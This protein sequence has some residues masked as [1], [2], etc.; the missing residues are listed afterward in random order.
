MIKKLLPFLL[1]GFAFGQNDL[2]K[3]LELIKELMPD[4]TRC[5]VFFNS[6]DNRVP[7][8]VNMSAQET[9]LTIVQ[10]PVTSIRE[11]ATAMRQMIQFDVDFVIVI[12]DRTV[13]GPNALRYLVK[14][15]NKRGKPL[16][17]ASE[18]AM[19]AGAAGKFARRGSDWY[20]Q[21]NGKPQADY[22]IQIP[23][24]N[25]SYVVTNN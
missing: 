9:E 14:Q 11:M 2:T 13:G 19:G 21:I 12:E 17:T 6:K 3:Q 20:L 18:N 10:A 16:F 24:D 25:A 23:A 15:N 22:K 4:A 8:M 5:A 7:P 1:V